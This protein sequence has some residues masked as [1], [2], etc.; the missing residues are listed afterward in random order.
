MLS[1]IAHDP[2]AGRPLNPATPTT[3]RV[4]SR[5]IRYQRAQP[6]ALGWRCNISKYHRCEPSS[7]SG[8]GQLEGTGTPN[9]VANCSTLCSSTDTVSTVAAINSSRVV[10]T[11]SGSDMAIPKYAS[12]DTVS[13]A[14]GSAVHPYVPVRRSVAQK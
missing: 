12:D 11:V 2:S 3:S 5:R 9:A 6:T 13:L 10:R 14:H 7:L 1:P 4:G 8:G